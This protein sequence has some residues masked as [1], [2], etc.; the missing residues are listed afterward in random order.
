MWNQAGP[1]RQYARLRAL[2]IAATLI[3][4]IAMSATLI[5][6]QVRSERAVTDGILTQARAHAQEFNAVRTYV[7]GFSG[8]YV[9]ASEECGV[10]PHLIGIPG[11]K[12]ALSAPDGKQYVL[13]N[14]PCVA[15]DISRIL[16][17]DSG[18]S[19]LMQL[20]ALDPINTANRPDAFTRS[21]IGQLDRGAPEVFAYGH[22]GDK[23]VFRY[24]L[25]IPLQPKCSRCH[26]PWTGQVSGNAGATV[27]QLDV[28]QPL[29]WISTSRAWTGMIILA[30]VLLSVVII[31]VL[32][33]LVLKP[34]HR[35]QL[36]VYDMARR[37]S[38]TGLNVRRIGME[39]LAEELSRAARDELRV[40][41][42]MLD[43]DDF[44]L[45]NDELGHSMGDRVLER[46]GAAISG[47]LRP[48][49]KAARVGGEEFLLVLP[50]AC[51]READEIVGRVRAEIAKV[52]SAM[53]E[54]GRTVTCSAGV[55]VYDPSSGESA[56]GLFM[57]ADH[58]L[59]AAKRAGKNRSLVS[60]DE[61][62]ISTGVLVPV[63]SAGSPE[64]EVL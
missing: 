36:Q 1:S 32:N 41:C 56:N 61:H 17:R 45:V 13:K 15:R 52:T 40:A 58:A 26:P 33:T 8:I 27:V 44:K 4:V 3:F 7:Q 62:P 20:S 25:G 14:A 55:A 39:S 28:T 5:L 23:Q 31:L 54:L 10:N 6:L 64:P 63:F 47:C 12:P 9:P 35:A 34:M 24:A 53:G 50:G 16:E 30:V 60:G 2:A 49:D 18:Q 37:D 42:C 29:A 46:V 22:A 48:Y 57:R 43:L 59:L 19:V 51:A 21:A 11:V 38:L